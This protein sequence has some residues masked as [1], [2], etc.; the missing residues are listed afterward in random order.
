VYTHILLAICGITWAVA[1]IFI[2]IF[3]FLSTTCASRSLEEVVIDLK[4]DCSNNHFDVY[5]NKGFMVL[6][7]P[8]ALEI[9]RQAL[10]QPPENLF[11]KATAAT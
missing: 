9:S 7:S 8:R 5:T 11:L 3:L 4:F 1:N 6:V 10:D 2:T